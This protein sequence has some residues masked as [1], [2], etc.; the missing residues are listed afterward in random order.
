MASTTEFPKVVELGDTIARLTLEEARSLV[1]HLQERLGVSTVAFTPAAVFAVP[2]VGGASTGAEEVAPAKKTEFDI[3]INEVPSSVRITT[4]K[5]VCALTSLVLKEAK[6]LIE[7]LPKNAKEGV[8]QASSGGADAGEHAR[9][10]LHG[11]LEQRGTCLLLT[12]DERAH[13][14]PVQRVAHDLGRARR[15]VEHGQSVL[16]VAEGQLLHDDVML[17]TR[18]TASSWKKPGGSVPRVKLLSQ[19]PSTLEL[20]NISAPEHRRQQSS[21]C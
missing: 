8:T 10:G 3:I 1:D 19:V 14:A 4:V 20:K 11:A 9:G 6:D 5:V 16:Q 12:G 17:P 15:L 13:L 7:G 18:A 2:G 21:S